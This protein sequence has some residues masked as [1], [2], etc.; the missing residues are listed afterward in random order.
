M[1]AGRRHRPQPVEPLQLRLAAA[2]LVAEHRGYGDDERALHWSA[3]LKLPD[4]S[5]EQVEAELTVR[6]LRR[7]LA[8][9]EGRG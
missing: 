9:A 2:V 4:G 8:L 5:R 1:S 6:D 7:V 3:T